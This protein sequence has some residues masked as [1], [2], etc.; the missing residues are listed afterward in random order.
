M[1]NKI[2]KSKCLHIIIMIIFGCYHA[3]AGEGAAIVDEEDIRF[4]YY[5]AVN[6]MIEDAK[7][8]SKEANLKE[9]FESGSTNWSG[10][11]Y[12]FTKN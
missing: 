10:E 9:L 1:K 3:M 4:I 11:C 5:Q 2:I 12:S 8:Q 6:N 7:S